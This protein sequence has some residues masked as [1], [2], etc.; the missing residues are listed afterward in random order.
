MKLSTDRVL[1]THTGSLPRPIELRDAMYEHQE[2]PDH[3]PATRLVSAAVT[4]IVKRQVTAGVDVVSDG[5]MSKPGFLNYVGDRLTG[6]GGQGDSWSF[7]DLEATPELADAQYQAEAATHI[8]PPRCIGPVAYV[9]HAAVRRDI[10]NL[11][12][13]LGNTPATDAFMS[14]ASPGVI[15]QH[16]PT[17][18]Y[19]SYQDYLFACADAMREEYQIIVE[20]GIV[21]QLDCPDLPTCWPG[22]GRYTVTPMV[23][24]MGYQSFLE[25]N[26]AALNH[27]LRDLPEDR[28]RMHLCW[29]NYAGPHRFDVPFAD[30]VAPVLKARP[31]AI[32]FEAA[33]PRHQHEWEVFEEVRLPDDK[34]IIPGVIDT[35]T[36]FVEHPRVVAQRI[37]RFARLVGRERV[38]AGTDCGFGTFVGFGLVP[39][40][41]T[42]LKLA[43]LAEGAALVSERLW[44]VVA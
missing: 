22:H 3:A 43:A 31:Q 6:F 27:A 4:E 24:E 12:A 26:I 39:S 14:A 28:L 35:L 7:T 16:F 30:L 15:T 17:D 32:S 11:K 2:H 37:E 33:N 8:H 13:A 9:G 25:L 40:S 44:S 36:P 42:W 29:G 18:H 23:E 5:E 19:D 38:I 10:D 41:V 21:L 1:T 34:V 20:A